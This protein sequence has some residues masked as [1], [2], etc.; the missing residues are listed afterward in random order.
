MHTL[1][2]LRIFRRHLTVFLELAFLRNGFV[3]E[4]QVLEVDL[5][6]AD[7]LAVHGDFVGD[8]F[9][10]GLSFGGGC[11]GDF[12]EVGFALGELAFID[13]LVVFG[14]LTQTV[15]LAL[16]PLALVSAVI[17]VVECSLA[18]FETFLIL[19]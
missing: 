1:L 5:G 13:D 14:E 9:Y 12:G 4:V 19:P 15:L 8:A 6:F 17:A 11:R 16:G 3:C 2:I 10:E 7:D 18:M